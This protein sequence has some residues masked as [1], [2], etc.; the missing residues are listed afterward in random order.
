V[1]PVLAAA[2]LMAMQHLAPCAYQ[3]GDPGR[4]AYIVFTSGTS[5]R[6]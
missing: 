2:D 6:A 5:G 4:L 1:A 3:M